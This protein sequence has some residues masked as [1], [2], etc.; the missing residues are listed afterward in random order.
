MTS[1]RLNAKGALNKAALIETVKIVPGDFNGDGKDDI[2]S[3][4]RV[5]PAYTQFLVQ[6]SNGSSFDKQTVW[7]ESTQYASS[8]LDTRIVAG[9]FNADGKDDLAVMYNYSGG[10][11]KLYTYLSNGSSFSRSQD[12]GTWSANIS[13]LDNRFAAGDFNGDGKDD[14]A[15]MFRYPT[16][17]VN[18]FTFL[19][20]GSSFTRQNWYE[21][22]AD[23][24]YVENRFVAGDFNGNGTDDL[25]VMFRYPTGQ[26][27]LF[28]F[29]STGS[30]FTRQNWYNWSADMTYVGNRF[31]A[32]DFNGNGKDDLAV[33]F[34]YP[35]GQVNIFSFL[36]TGSGFTREVWYEWSAD[37]AYA[38]DRFAA[39]DF[40]GDGKDDVVVLFK[41]PS[42]Q[43]NLFTFLSTGNNFTRQNWYEWSA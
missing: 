5:G 34:G 19:S 8:G 39:G 31:T 43:V 14:V 6:L 21:W 38:E 13:Y 40:N 25:A 42:G 33:M 7:F 29:L 15:V 23:M 20:T 12:W 11:I 28:T 27:N 41:Y 10:Q 3:I 24:N 2:A 37:M 18:L 1:G 9:D 30:S 36:S 16:G 26:V 17:E 32:G 22:S 4:V 35:S